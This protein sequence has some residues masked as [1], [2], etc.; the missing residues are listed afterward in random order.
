MDCSQ[1]GISSIGQNAGLGVNL[2]PIKI[3]PF[4]RRSE[5]LRIVLGKFG[6]IYFECQNFRLDWFALFN[7][8]ELGGSVRYVRG[9]ARKDRPRWIRGMELGQYLL[10]PASSTHALRVT[11]NSTAAIRSTFSYPGSNSSSPN[12]SGSSSR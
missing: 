7:I 12:T 9:E 10:A 1:I 4:F 8:K 2:S 5:H 3:Q 11:I 6:I